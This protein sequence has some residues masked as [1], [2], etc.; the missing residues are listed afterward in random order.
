MKRNFVK[1]LVAIMTVM[2]FVTG[3]GKKENDRLVLGFV[4]LIDGDK[5][6]ESTKPLSEILSKA[7]GKEVEIVTA[8]NY[9]GVVEGISSSKIDFGIIPPFAYV[10][11]NKE[12]GADVILK[13]LNKHGKSYYRSQFFVRKNSGIKTV[14]DVRGKRVAFVDPSSSSG[15]LYPGA[16]LKKNG[17]D[18]EKDIEVVYSGGHDKSLQ[19][20]INGDVDVVAVYEGA[21]EKYSKEFKELIEKTE[22]LF[23]SDNIPYISVTVRGD[24]EK[25][26]KEEIKQGLLKG[27][28]SVEGKEIT[29]KLFNLHGFEEAT[30]ADYEGIRTT[31]E[32]M[33]INLTK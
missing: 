32:V 26:L 12:S 23:Y 20:L 28:N 29:S 11:A 16:Y 3:C 27:L 1:I 33:D 9:V 19:L 13:A 17:L 15:Y 5:L 8:T 18:L 21:R 2:L 25:E 14:E 10:L 7:L 30:D 24:M 6:I 22:S 4:P 31:A